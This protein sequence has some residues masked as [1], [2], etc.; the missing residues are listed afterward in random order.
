MR[1]RNLCGRYLFNDLFSILWNGNLMFLPSQIKDFNLYFLENITMDNQ[2][3][4]DK[5][6]F[7]FFLFKRQTGNL[8]TLASSYDKSV[9]ASTLF[10]M[11]LHMVMP[12]KRLRLEQNFFLLPKYKRCA[13]YLIAIF[14]ISVAL[15]I[16]K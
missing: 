6:Q 12:W 2:Y 14:G 10:L 8:M 11:L 16:I 9:F 13:T 15:T 7:L 5:T 4:L 1:K 3:R